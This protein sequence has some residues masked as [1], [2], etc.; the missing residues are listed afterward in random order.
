MNTRNKKKTLFGSMI[1][2]LALLT[3]SSAP[4][5]QF[6]SFPEKIR[7][8]Q[9]SLTQ[10]SLTMPVTATLTSTDPDVAHVSSQVSEQVD[11]SKP[12]TIQ[13]G[14][15]GGAKLTMRLGN[16]PIKT[17]DV[18][19]L[20]ELKVIPGGQSIGVQL[21]TVGVLVVG[22][23]LVESQGKKFSPGEVANV[24]VGDMITAINNVRVRSMDEVGKI[25]D[26]AGKK[27]KALQLEILRGKQTI[28]VDLTPALDDKDKKY[29]MGL[30]IR[31]SAAGVGTLTF[32]DP[33]SRKYGALGHVISDMDTGKA[34]AVGEGHVVQSSVTSIEPGKSGAP[35]EKY[36]TFRNERVKLGTIEKNTPFGIFGNMKQM[37]EQAF[38]K[39]P[40]PIALGE[41]VKPGPAEIY[42]VVEDQ[43]VEKFKIE[44]VN[45]VPQKYP[46]TKGLILKVTDPVLLK[47]TGGIVQGMSGSPIIQDGKLVGA[48]THVFVNDPT[49]GYGTYI[50][51]MLQ[52]AGIDLTNQKME[53]K[54]R[55]S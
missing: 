23:H 29:R 21:H 50:E 53:E 26:E 54:R 6:A 39:E 47:K 14:K 48:V 8:F 34:I 22:Q 24:K 44:I 19:V 15:P 52:D 9:G 32:F 25:V 37:P 41:Q 10:L 31:D 36:A 27:G 30:Y 11:L 51:W 4:F 33:K 1:L 45:V 7:M 28:T 40:I 38:T 18:E 17:V 55:V 49:S 12:L 35:G 5:Q 46:A 16:I 43:K 3:F 42:T 20:P 13:P 2:V